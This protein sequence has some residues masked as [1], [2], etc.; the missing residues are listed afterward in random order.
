MENAHF[1][2]QA[3]EATYIGSDEKEVE[4]T[5]VDA[6]S[7]SSEDEDEEDDFDID[8][9]NRNKHIKKDSD[10][11]STDSDS[12]EDSNNIENEIEIDRALATISMA[13]SEG[14]HEPGAPQYI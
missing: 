12:S 10:D 13:D 9:M 4:D 1:D 14:L 2:N 11:S 5:K 7:D 8:G 6:V 3:L